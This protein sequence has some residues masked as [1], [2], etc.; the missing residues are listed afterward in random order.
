MAGSTAERAAEPLRAP[1]FQ[2]VV[3]PWRQAGT[4][5]LDL[6]SLRLE[7]GQTSR[8]GVLSTDIEWD[9]YLWQPWFLQMRFGL[10]LLAA[11]DTSSHGADTHGS[12]GGTSGTV[13]GRM[14]LALF[15]AS[16]FPF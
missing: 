11:R 3:A 12:D 9:S 4:V 10:G 6:R 7:D 16:R 2:W 15:P 5:S 14:A 8:Q 1:G 13:T